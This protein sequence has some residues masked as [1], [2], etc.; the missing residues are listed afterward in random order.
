MAM[1]SM[2]QLLTILLTFVS[3]TAFIYTLGAEYLGLN[4]LFSNILSI[5][6]LSELGIGGAIA[7]YLYK[8]LADKDIDRIKVLMKFY[9]R[10]YNYVGLAI[11]GLGCCLMPFLHYLVNLEQS[12]PEN[13]YLIYFIFILQNSCTYFFFAYKQTLV[14]ANQEL[15]K[16]EKY[17]IAFSFINCIT[18]IVVLL[19]FRNFIVY[20]LFKL[21]LVIVKNIA[22]SNKINREYP[23]ITDACDRKLTKEEKHRFFKNLYSISIFKVGSTLFNTLSNLMI[24]IMIGTVVVGYYS[25]YFMI[26]SQVNVIYMLIMTAVSAGVGNVIAK[27]SQEHQV[28]IYNKLSLITFFIYSLFT[29]CLFQLLNSFMHIWLGRVDSSYI[30]NQWVVLFICLNFYIDT[31][32]Q[33]DNVFRNASGHFKIG[34]YLQIWGGLLNVAL[35]VSLCHF[36]GLTGIFAAQ[37]LSKLFTSYFPFI[38]NVQKVVLGFSRKMVMIVWAKRFLLLIGIGTII[39]LLCLPIHETTLLNFVFEGVITLVFTVAVLWMVF[40]KDENFVVVRDMAISKVK[41]FLYN[42]C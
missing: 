40:C 19:V 27:E 30:L 28:K 29:I 20:L 4:G 16:I 39:W 24:S 34:R 18:D 3:R 36:Y 9:R 35:A 15:Y 12:L 38:M 37:V 2:R 31:S 23:Y 1:S 8:P 21:V 22:I 17:N 5:L 26:T 7:F 13:L 25:N 32:C 41:T 14:S 10:C 6:A 33:L 11:L 42:R